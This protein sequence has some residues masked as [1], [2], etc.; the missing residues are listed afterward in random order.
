MA[1]P[2]TTPHARQAVKAALIG[3]RQA[4][5]RAN[6]SLTVQEGLYRAYMAHL[7]DLDPIEGVPE[8]LKSAIHDLV[9]ELRAVFGFDEAT[10]AKLTPS[11]LG[12]QHATLLLA[13]LKA[14]A[15]TAEALAVHELGQRH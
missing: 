2:R 14:I 15:A 1:I 3:L 11:T 12:R 13:R 6:E 4:L 8:T 5:A 7:C 9:V 10:G